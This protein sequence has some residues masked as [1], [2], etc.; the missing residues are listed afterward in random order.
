[1]VTPKKPSVNNKLIL[2]ASQKP[3][4]VLSLLTSYYTLLYPV[5]FCNIL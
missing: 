1:M 2:R 3:D 5:I 4:F